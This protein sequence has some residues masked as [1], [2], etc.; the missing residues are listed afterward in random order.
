MKKLFSLLALF[1]ALMLLCLPGLAENETPTET[2]QQTQTQPATQPETK[3]VT[4]PA[5]Q[6]ETTP[7]TE[8]KPT[9]EFAVRSVNITAKLPIAG[10]TW[11]EVLVQ[12]IKIAAVV[13][14][15]AKTLSAPLDF[16]M[17]SSIWYDNA[18]GTEKE[19]KAEEL[20]VNG[21]N[22]VLKI[23]F[24]LYVKY[25]ELDGETL[26][27]INGK[28]A[29][30]SRKGEEYEVK[31]NFVCTP[32]DLSPNVSLEVDGK[33]TKEYDGKEITL[34]A[35]VEKTEG[36][37][38]RYEWYCNGKLMQNRT[39]STLTLKDVADSGKY[40]CKVYATPAGDTSATGDATEST[41]HEIV[42]TPHKVT[43]QIEDVQKNLM[44]PDPEF[45]FTVIGEVYDEIIGKPE[46]KAGEE[47]GTYEITA[48]TLSFDETVKENYKLEILPGKLTIL[49][50]SELA[51]T[52]L[53]TFEDTSGI[54]GV[55]D[56][57]IRVSASKDAIPAGATVKIS[58]ASEDAL[59]KLSSLSGKKMMKSFTVSIVDA[60]GKSIA[61]PKH[62]ALKIQVPLTKDETVFKKG[63][64]TA[65]LY[66]GSASGAL[67]CETVTTGDFLYIAVELRETGTV[68]IFE[69]DR[70]VSSKPQGTEKAP[71]GEEEKPKTD[72]NIFLWIFAFLLTATALGAIIFTI[73][74]KQK[75]AP[76]NPPRKPAAGTAAKRT[77]PPPMGRTTGTLRPG[78]AAEKE[79]MRRIADE[80]NAM[81]PIPEAAPQKNKSEAGGQAA[82]PVPP[83]KTVSFED[84]ED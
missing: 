48:G 84:L 68:A 19:M 4:Q 63:S 38:Y 73:V 17:N 76:K 66:T 33:K 8:E 56:S 82:A 53:S 15:E 16:D 41:S 77:P 67:T 22:Y 70:P 44:D 39:D 42:I 6:P 40:Y 51:F 5:T 13:N 37:N 55:S 69:G 47:L 81:P 26:L 78:D 28:K 74:W 11:S 43:V 20:F 60:N 25:L 36:V 31:G 1:L 57:K 80:I 18:T 62:G 14:G 12:N 71:K 2:P 52:A 9:G 10:E 32:R 29:E 7:V 30:L 50:A 72:G 23:R 58:V 34:T 45:S 49:N 64:I 65:G 27:F 83:K 35:K 59:Q 61:L 54:T 79:R 46:R 3:P 75:N 24:S 21:R